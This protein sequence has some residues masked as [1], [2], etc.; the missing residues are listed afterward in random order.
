MALATAA[1]IG[2]GATANVIGSEATHLIDSATH[3]VEDRIHDVIENHT[4]GKKRGRA[5]DLA[6]VTNDTT[7]HMED[8]RAADEFHS[9]NAQNVNY[10]VH[11]DGPSHQSH[12]CTCA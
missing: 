4:P 11:S 10:P 6:S 8:V 9:T 1:A 5:R 7:E 2:I 12:V 3:Y